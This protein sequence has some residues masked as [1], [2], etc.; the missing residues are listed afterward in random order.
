MSFFKKLFGGGRKAAR[1]EEAPE[2]VNEQF[3]RFL[4]QVYGT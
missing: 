1:E 2:A 3:T 4:A